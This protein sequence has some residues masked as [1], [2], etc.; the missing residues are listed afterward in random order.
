MKVHVDM[1]KCTGFGTCAEVAPAVFA[2]D[3]FGYAQLLVTDELALDQEVA[4][5]DAARKCG[6]QAI[7]C[8]K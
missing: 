3:E 2:I 8:E 5:Q 6:A 1:T 4:A 7:T